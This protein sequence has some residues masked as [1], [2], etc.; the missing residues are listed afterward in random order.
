M[1]R[2]LLFLLLFLPSIAFGQLYGTGVGYVNGTPT[3][4]PN[5][6][7]KGSELCVS[8]NDHMLYLWNRDSLEWYPSG[9]I[10]ISFGVPTTAP[11][12][13]QTRTAINFVTG[14]IYWWNGSA[15]KELISYSVELA[16]AYAATVA[17]LYANQVRDELADSM[18]VARAYTDSLH[19]AD[20]DRDS[21]NEFQN[22]VLIGSVLSITNG[23]AVDFASLLAGYLLRSDTSSLVATR[24]YVRTNP[25]TIAANAVVRSNGSNLVA[26]NMTDNG[27]ELEALL[28]FKLKAY[29]TAGLPV[30]AVR[31]MLYN[32]DIGGP[33]WHDGTRYNYVPKA[34]RSAFTSTYIPF[35]NS[36]GQFTEHTGIRYNSATADFGLGGA[37]SAQLHLQGSKSAAS[38]TTSGIGI[39]V[40]AAIYTNTTSSGTV[41]AIA[42]HS[43]GVPTFSATSTTTYTQSSTL[44]VAAPLSGANVTQTEP[45]AIVAGPSNIS[46]LVTEYGSTLFNSSPIS[47]ATNKGAI[48]HYI[49]SRPNASNAMGLYSQVTPTFNTNSY[50]VVGDAI[51]TAPAAG[52]RLTG[53]YGS[54][55]GNS[56]WSSATTIIGVQG[57]T[58]GGTGAAGNHNMF[59]V[60][61][62]TDLTSAFGGGGVAANYAASF[63]AATVIRNN[64]GAST[65][66]AFASAGIGNPAGSLN[67]ITN[68][69]PLALNSGNLTNV[70]N[71]WSYLDHKLSVGSTTLSTQELDVFGD[72][73]IRDSL[74]LTST[75]P[76]STI[77]GLLT[78]N[79]TGWVGLDSIGKKGILRESGRLYAAQT[80]STYVEDSYFDIATSNTKDEFNTFYIWANQTASFTDSMFIDLPPPSASLYMHNIEIYAESESAS[81]S[82]QIYVRGDI[83]TNH[84]PPGPE[85]ILQLTNIS[86]NGYTYRFR[87]ME[88]DGVWYWVLS[89]QP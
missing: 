27:T 20:N 23:N 60:W 71:T 59:G 13:S 64:M 87:K 15:W 37:P 56:G 40:D 35:V 63:Y 83:W 22:L 5:T 41:A 34:D 89:K 72:A 33:G 65:V 66:S 81:L 32:T 3:H 86:T 61:G 77:S 70:T 53:V 42:A 30:G 12:T 52:G 10:T 17:E 48:A 38:W 43:L 76:H 14:L 88:R 25:T 62:E 6:A 19:L 2:I 18:V 80:S 55:V 79:S 24:Y 28:P 29:T 50:G 85:S 51:G 36:L 45:F 75:P 47:A 49:V 68:Y 44:R 21:T 31:Q 67:T 1:T 84:A 54:A 7:Q 26:G 16:S 73:Y 9:A 57:Y 78:K 39:R 74:R 46:R 8:I 4:T 69:N 11:D 82:D 58:R